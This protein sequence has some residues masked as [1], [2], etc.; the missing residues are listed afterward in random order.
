M[1]LQDRLYLLLREEGGGLPPERIAREVFHFRNGDLQIQRHLV[2]RALRDDPR[3]RFDPSAD[4][5]ILES[6]GHRFTV[7]DLETTGMRPAEAEI[8]EIGA[9]RVEDR[10]ITETWGKLIRPTRGVPPEIERLTGISNTMVADAPSLPEVL[11]D[12]LDFLGETIF[13]A[14]NVGFD[15]KFI[16]TNVE[17]IL[18][19][20]LENSRICTVKMSRKLL[21]GLPNH[22]LPTIAAHF[23]FE[24]TSHH[25]AW[26]DSEVTARI[27]LRLLDLLD[28]HPDLSLEDFLT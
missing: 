23:G 17:Q 13:V 5:W 16:Q 26:E 22:R 12:F 15:W 21:D 20:K 6:P 4:L 8:I 1:T 10:K 25:R 18:C 9:V 11:P 2:E 3:F 24:Q 19:R 14:H 7:V 28:A 27:F